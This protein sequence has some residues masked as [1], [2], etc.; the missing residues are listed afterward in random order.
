MNSD[1]T[2]HAIFTAEFYDLTSIVDI[3]NRTMA[4][5]TNY[6]KMFISAENV[7]SVNINK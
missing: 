4:K 3:Q 6:R 7:L 5:A 2:Q 1:N